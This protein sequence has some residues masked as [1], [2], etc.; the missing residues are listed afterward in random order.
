MVSLVTVAGQN[1]CVNMTVNVC[2]E[3][4]RASRSTAFGVGY[5]HGAAVT[6][7]MNS[8]LTLLSPPE[9]FRPLARPPNKTPSADI[10]LLISVGPQR[11]SAPG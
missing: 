10:S 6:P 5:A 3:V 8:G 1:P 11:L 4:L 7:L 2:H 9:I